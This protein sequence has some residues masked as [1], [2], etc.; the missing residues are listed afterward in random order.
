M[1][2]LYLLNR[3]CSFTPI[4]LRDCVDV[5]VE[6]YTLTKSN[7]LVLNVDGAIESNRGERK[8]GKERTRG[9]RRRRGEELKR[10]ERKKREKSE[11]INLEEWTNE[12]IG[13]L[14][15]EWRNELEEGNKWSLEK[16]KQ[17]LKEAIKIEL[18]QRGSL[19]TP[20]GLGKNI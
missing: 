6:N 13:N 19:Y 18:S 12:M 16:M 14:K 20:G 2:F 8:K 11:R 4:W 7:N 1:F 3:R 15:E 5:E 17:K 10:R 9:G